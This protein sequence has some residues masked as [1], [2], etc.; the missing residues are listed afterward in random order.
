MATTKNSNRGSISSRPKSSA[1]SVTTT[2][3]SREKANAISPLPPSAHKLLSFVS[4]ARN[5][6]APEWPEPW[7][8]LKRLGESDI[9]GYGNRFTYGAIQ[10]NAD[11]ATLAHCELKQVLYFGGPEPNGFDLL[12][13][14]MYWQLRNCFV[15]EAASGDPY[16]FAHA[17]WRAYHAGR[18]SPARILPPDQK[19]FR[20]DD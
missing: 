14:P 12:T 11:L 8:N 7:P 15:E 5:T 6:L 2:P 4:G 19:P 13:A 16:A 20:L 1:E 10:A 18:L 17:I 9:D 3:A